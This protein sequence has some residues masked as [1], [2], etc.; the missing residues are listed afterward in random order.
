MFM[1]VPICNIPFRQNTATFVVS[2][3]EQARLQQAKEDAAN[4]LSR[5]HIRFVCIQHGASSVKK[6]RQEKPTTHTKTLKAKKQVCDGGHRWRG[7]DHLPFI[8]GHLFKP[9]LFFYCKDF[10]GFFSPL[11]C[12]AFLL[13]CLA[14]FSAFFA[15][16]L[17]CFS[18][19]LH[20]CFLLLCYLLFC[21]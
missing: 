3:L 4:K 8:E 9:F 20:L 6:E 12:A 17:F 13:V 15:S 11:Y 14:C 7:R 16:L 1:Y 10:F 19:F 21:Y 18:A 2:R 5:R